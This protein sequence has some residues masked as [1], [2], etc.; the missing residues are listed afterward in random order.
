MAERIVH[1]S[2]TTHRTIEVGRRSVHCLISLPPD[3]VATQS[4]AVQL[5]PGLVSGHAIFSRYAPILNQH[6]Y[7]TV[8]IEHGHPSPDNHEDVLRVSQDLLDGTF[9]IC[10]D[11]L[12]LATHSLGTRNAVQ[13]LVGDAANDVRAHTHSLIE[14]APVGYG[15]VQFVRGAVKTLMHEFRSRPDQKSVR[16]LAQDGFWY[17]VR[18]GVTLRDQIHEAR[19]CDL[20]EATQKLISYGIGVGAVL[21]TQ[22]H[23]I[24]FHTVRRGLQIAGVQW[25]EQVEADHNGVLF[26]PQETFDAAMAIKYGIDHEKKCNDTQRKPYA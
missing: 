23:L 12:S 17:S 10:V 4:A 5:C 8:V 9:G 24:D 13:A 7:P 22:D 21:Y 1:K 26:K 15:G 11:E 6:G 16:S 25:I 19:A 3:D 20:V 18:A 14:I 2:I